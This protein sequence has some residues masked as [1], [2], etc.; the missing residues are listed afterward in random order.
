MKRT[1]KLEHKF[2]GDGHPAFIVFEAGPTHNGFKSAKELIKV[3][4]VSGAD[5][6]KFQIFDP[7]QLI[8]D[9]SVQY[10]YDW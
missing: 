1:I 5:A 10:E 4:A 2:V 6:I 3:A 9:K 7:D 8:S